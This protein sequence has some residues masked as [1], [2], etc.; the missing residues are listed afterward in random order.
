MTDHRAVL[1]EFEEDTRRSTAPRKAVVKAVVNA[2]RG[3]SQRN[4][5]EEIFSLGAAIS[6]AAMYGKPIDFSAASAIL[7]GAAPLGSAWRVYR[8]KRF[9]FLECSYETETDCESFSPI[10]ILLCSM[11]IHLVDEFVLLDFTSLL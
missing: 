10:R 11:L 8:C 6:C 4:K 3:V 5:Q 2:L 7:N 1:I 9:C